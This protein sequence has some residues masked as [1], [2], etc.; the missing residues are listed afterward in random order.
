[1]NQL[2]S[3]KD[4]KIDDTYL[5]VITSHGQMFWFKLKST[6][7]HVHFKKEA[8]LLQYFKGNIKTNWNL[9]HIL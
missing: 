3:Q 6:Y 4:F 8:K 7:K 1:M 5:L 2:L 9:A